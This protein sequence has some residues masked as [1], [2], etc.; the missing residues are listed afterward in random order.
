MICPVCKS[1]GL[2][3]TVSPGATFGTCMGYSH[4]H[5]DEAGQ[6]VAH[7]DPNLYTTDYSC[8]RGHHF[9]VVRQQGEADRVRVAGAG[10]GPCFN[11]SDD[12]PFAAQPEGNNA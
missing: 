11:A 12:A 4:G 9:D 5:Y 8:S 1:E 7:R 3:S 2:K 6:W 10:K